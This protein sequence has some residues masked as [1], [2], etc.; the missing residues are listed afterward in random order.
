MDSN[1]PY[2][3]KMIIALDQGIAADL[4]LYNII[5]DEAIIMGRR[6]TKALQTQRGGTQLLN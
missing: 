2:A 1:F 3:Q 4:Q 6:C 5:S